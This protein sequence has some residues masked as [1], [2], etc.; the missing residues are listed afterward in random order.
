[1]PTLT[2]PTRIIRYVEEGAGPLVLLLHG[3]PGEGREWRPLIDEL[4]DG[5]HMVAPDFPG[6]GDAAGDSPCSSPA[7]AAE[8]VADAIVAFGAPAAHLVGRQF[9]AAVAVELAR[10]HPGV[11]TSVTLLSPD[12]SPSELTAPA[13]VLPA[14]QA[15]ADWAA[16][17][18]H[19]SDHL[20][21]VIS[22]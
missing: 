20:L 3:V 21:A 18:R 6:H 22:D 5:F 15:L 4:V 9:G 13:I 19:V 16:I 17:G 11:V 12:E 1:M 2:T 7:D 8:F 14:A 10:Q